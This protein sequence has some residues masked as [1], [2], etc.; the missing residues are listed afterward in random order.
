[1]YKLQACLVLYVPCLSVWKYKF[2]LT[3]M[4]AWWRTDV[5]NLILTS[6]S[7]NNKGLH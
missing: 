1:M 6:N 5:C 7:F 3:S 4:Y 2:Q